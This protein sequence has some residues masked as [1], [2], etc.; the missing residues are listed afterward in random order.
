MPVSSPVVTGESYTA[1]DINNLRTDVLD[2]HTHD[3]TEG[4]LVPFK[5]LAVTGTDGSTRPSGGN[6]SYDEIET[7]V[8]ATQGAHGLPASVYFVSSPI[9]KAVV[10]GGSDS[11]AGASKAVSF[12]FTFASIPAVV[13][14]Y[15]DA[16]DSSLTGEFDAAYVD[17]VTTTGFDAKTTSPKWEDKSFNWIAIGISS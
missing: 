5:N 12:G 14:S 1:D 10:I 6:V 13:I 3:G 15:S 9:N 2:G 16:F 4:A 11:F 8:A 17:N 7:H